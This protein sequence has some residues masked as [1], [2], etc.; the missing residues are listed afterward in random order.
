MIQQVLSV[1]AAIA[2]R[3]RVELPPQWADAARDLPPAAAGVEALEA[4][5]SVLGWPEAR[6]IEGPGAE[7]FPLIAIDG[8]GRLA[9]AEQWET[10]GLVRV[11]FEREVEL[12]HVQ[13][14]EVRF[15]AVNLPRPASDAGQGAE[16]PRALSIFI[17]A[18]KRRKKMLFD[19]S[20]ATIVLNVI[21]LGTSLYTM[22]V[23]DRVVP[24]AGF[25]T[26]WVLTFGV[27][28]ATLLD[29]GLR[30]VRSVMIEKE[31][32]N[33]DAEVSEFFF[34]RAQAVRLDARDGGVGTLAA[35][36]RSY[37][38]VRSLLSSATIFALADLP[39][40]FFF[41]WVI[42]M[43]AGPVAW[44]PLLSFIV[45]VG[46]ALVVARLI[47]RQA[48][49]AHVGAN[50]KNGLMVESLDAAETIKANRGNWHMLARW[51]RLV[52][53]VEEDEYS[54]KKVTA[55]SQAAGAML[56]QVAYVALIAWGAVEIIDGNMTVGALIASSIISGR[57]NG[58]LVLQLPSLIVQSSYARSALQGLDSFLKLP[59]DRDP[60]TDYLRPAGLENRIKLDQV[61]F[62][63]P[64]ARSGVAVS[65]LAIQP[66]ERVA[67]IGPVG[68]GKTTLLKIL[69]G[70][71]PPQ[72]GTA[73]IDGLDMNHL[74]EDLLRKQI[75]YLGQE[76]RLING[77]LRDQLTVGLSDPGD[78]AIIKAAE[79]TG[80]NQLVAA[81]PKG[82][83][84]PISEGGRGLSGGQRTLAGLTRMLLAKPGVWLL[85]EPTAAMDQD[86]EE[87]VL[88]AIFANLASQD[89]L[90]FVTHKI[91][92]LNLVQRVIVLVNG[93]IILDGPTATVLETLRT[94]AAPSS[95]Q[96]VQA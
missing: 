46:M 55:I 17:G 20:L 82:L 65:N 27:A 1:I 11:I 2:Q 30:A 13:D 43:L 26:L 79:A 70:L 74:A 14:R 24:R 83:E 93:Q 57:I 75:G 29:F 39:F 16:S 96:K 84:L 8:D 59:V 89:S 54:L 94:N 21:T 90:V 12:W 18:L 60:E 45:A 62:A 88:R 3:R 22:Q 47:R 36:L 6:A 81:H 10:P 32:A 92:L 49:G 42:Y 31:S 35:Q 19:A 33:I 50:R 52:A 78:E 51:N 53:D 95:V 41:I 15:F 69:A 80:L 66:G 77:T 67:I 85:D 87:R 25:S 76:Y 5:L 28:V 63:Y 58:P 37:D 71:Y 9:L 86:S 73:L 72:K 40:A 64:G 44:V 34:A 23:Y 48:E 38:Q 4:T 68:S 7:D 56:Q 61:S 91:Q